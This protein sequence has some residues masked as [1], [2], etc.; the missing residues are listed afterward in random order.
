MKEI[1]LIVDE[2]KCG[3]K[4]SKGSITQTA[5]RHF[6]KL[7]QGKEI[8]GATKRTEGIFVSTEL[9][10][11]EITVRAGNRWQF[12]DFG[13]AWSLFQSVIVTKYFRNK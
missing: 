13:S 6:R 2:L 9:L 11:S 1:S 7:S 8:D 4:P 3:R 5:Y 12:L 10:C